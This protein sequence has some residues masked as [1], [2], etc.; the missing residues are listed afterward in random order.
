MVISD[1]D[2]KALQIG[3]TI[4][5]ILLFVFVY[6]YFFMAKITIKRIELKT[7]AIN[8]DISDIEKK[9][10]LVRSFENRK[11][12]I[13]ALS[14]RVIETGKRL[15]TSLE[16]SVF[17]SALVDILKET[18]LAYQEIAPESPVART[19]YTE[20][21]YKITLSSSYHDLGQFLNLVEENPKRVMRVNQFRIRNDVKQ[22]SVHPIS[23]RLSTF[24]LK[25][26]P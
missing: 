20:I 7:T 5:V 1:Q 19:L 3:G 15:P 4:A 14:Q 24:L 16:P 25:E 22:P 21:P 8:K 9:L 13:E 6:Y 26:N 11:S 10:G 18:G 23:L 17:Y 12:E 2:K